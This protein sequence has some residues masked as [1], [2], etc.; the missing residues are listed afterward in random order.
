[1]TLHPTAPPQDLDAEQSVLG[2]ILLSDSVLNRVAADAGLR[3]EHFYRPSHGLIYGAML[4]LAELGEPIDSLTLRDALGRRG[5]LDAIGGRAAIDLLSAAVPTVG[6]VRRYAEIVVELAT[7]RRLLAATHAIQE[8]LAERPQAGR[9]LLADAEQRIFTIGQRDRP[10]RHVALADAIS[11]ELARLS[12]AA[13]DPDGLA[14][15]STGLPDLDRQLAGLHPGNLVVLAARP[16]MGKSCLALNVAVHA[17]FRV[18][19]HVLFCTLEM[20]T[21]ETVQRHL[22]AET[23]IA[24]ERLRNADLDSGQWS[25]LV[26]AGNAAQGTRFTLLEDTDLSVFDLRSRAR[27]IAVEQGGLDLVVVDYLQLLRADPPT[28]NRT[29]DVSEFSRGLKRLARDL[30]CPVLALAQLNRA[31]EARND[32]RPL[33]SDLRESGSIEADADVVLMLYRE[34][35]YD[36]DTERPGETDILIRKAR[37]GA[38]GEVTVAF[39]ADRQR[40]S[41]LP[42]VAA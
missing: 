12:A 3:P 15:L 22:A 8:Q 33:L 31:V 2:A 14:G 17:A 32:K 9:A 13:E 35:Y 5:E 1:M 25:R 20:S 41:S 36:P 6:H 4:A 10:R 30:D 29:E 16:A 38:T 21:S 37:S 7:A 18:D 39:D 19:A 24:A 42:H 40:F 28:G 11:T 23:G 34:E 26:A 27:Q